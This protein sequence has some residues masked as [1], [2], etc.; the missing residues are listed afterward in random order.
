MTLLC[1]YFFFHFVLLKVIE[2][3]GKQMIKLK[4]GV[5]VCVC[6]CSCSCGYVV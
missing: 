6:V 2:A 1:D 3:G 4:I 5:R